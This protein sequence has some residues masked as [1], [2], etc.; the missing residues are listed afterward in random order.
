VSRRARAW[1]QYV[2]S[3]RGLVMV[4]AATI[5]ATS[6]HTNYPPSK[7]NLK[8]KAHPLDASVSHLFFLKNRS[9]LLYSKQTSRFSTELPSYKAGT[10]TSSNTSVSN[11]WFPETLLLSTYPWRFV[12]P[13]QV[14]RG[15]S[16]LL[17]SNSSAQ[18]IILSASSP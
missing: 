8:E 13:S 10:N 1:M 14:N 2:T 15:G 17:L 5:S 9:P 3:A 18:A 7:S 11:T 16:R 6:P 12:P 4:V